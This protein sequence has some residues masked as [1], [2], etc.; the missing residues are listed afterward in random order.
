MPKRSKKFLLQFALESIRPIEEYIE[1][2]SF[3]NWTREAMRYDATILRL[4]FL[5]FALRDLSKRYRTED[6]KKYLARKAQRYN[7]LTEDYR[8]IDQ[9]KIWKTVTIELP[10]LKIKLQSQTLC[11]AKKKKG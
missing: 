11:D 8:K 4:E 10:R 1:G 6:T 2:L 7:A 5:G 3:S 9:R